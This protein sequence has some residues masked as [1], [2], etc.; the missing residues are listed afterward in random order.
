VPSSFRVL[1]ALLDRIEDPLTGAPRHAELVCEVPDE[2]RAQAAAAAAVV[3]APAAAFPMLPGV[4]AQSADPAEQVLDRTW[5]AALEVIGLAGAP[6]P[7]E[8]GAVL[9]PATT[10]SLALRV[11]P[12]CDAR[13]ASDAVL[14]ALTDDVPHGARV[15]IGR[16]EVADGWD[17]PPTAPWLER[18]LAAA[19]GSWFGAPVGHLGE[20]GGIPF[21]AMLG[22]RFP[23]AQFLVT[24]VLGPGS[25]AHGPNEFVDLAYAER[26]A[27]CV[28]EVLDAHARR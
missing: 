24:G 10:A 11:P 27:G 14:R 9:R 21:M 26:L 3:G 5:R 17:A 18:A 20:G 7:G 15:T 19:G 12:R 1:R 16:H 2:R 13:A 6:P 22:R 23:E 25:N 28:A 4:R 8:G